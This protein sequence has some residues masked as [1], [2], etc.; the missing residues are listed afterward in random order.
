MLLRLVREIKSRERNA[1][2][3]KVKY[4]FADIESQARTA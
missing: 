4:E 1:S 3:W 2:T